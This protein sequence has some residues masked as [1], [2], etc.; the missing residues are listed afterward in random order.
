MKLVSQYQ[1]L[2]MA[3]GP[4]N[5][6]PRILQ[7]MLQPVINHRGPEFKELYQGMIRK[8]KQVFQTKGDVFFLTSSGTGTVECAIQNIVPHNGKVLVQVNGFFSERLSDGIK[9][10]GGKPVPLPCEWG[11][12]PN[13][14]DFEKIIR[15]EKDLS[16]IAV[17]YN[18]T[19]TGATT[20]CMKEL[21]ELCDEQ[22]IPLMVDAISI[23]G[24]DQLPVDEWNVDLCIT[25]S[26]KCLMCPPGLGL[27]SVSEGAWDRIRKN[28][29]RHGYYFDLQSFKKYQEEGF[30]PFTPSLPLYYALDEA[31]NMILEE[32]LEARFR[33]HKKCA[34]ASYAGAEA[35]GLE[36][37]T[38]GSTRSNTVIALNNPLGVQVQKLL[39]LLRSKYRVVLAGG[40]G[41]LRDKIFRIGNMGTISAAEVTGTLGALESALQDM[42]YKFKAG[43][44]LAAASAKLRT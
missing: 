17:L 30:T 40:V 21:G 27:I 7:A 26:Q 8:A 14:Q 2:M 3:P 5:V 33:R 4:T 41:K 10:H 43:A 20:R 15:R 39:E 37:L 22:D 28:Q 1:Q 23:L 31:L 42:N 44:G 24:G 11:E 19:S 12:A 25:A 38:K 13:F 18:E 29:T 34:D 36:S 6:P 32:G 9:A 16:L 35:I